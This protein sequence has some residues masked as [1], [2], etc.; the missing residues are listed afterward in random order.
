MRVFY[1]T[2]ETKLQGPFF[3]LPSDGT[4]VLDK[5]EEH[6][7]FSDAAA[8]DDGVVLVEVKAETVILVRL[9]VWAPAVCSMSAAAAS[10]APMAAAKAVL[11]AA[12]F[13]LS[14]R[15]SASLSGYFVSTFCA[16]TMVATWRLRLCRRSVAILERT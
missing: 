10:A 4:M 7:S 14:C 16:L 1:A 15:A 12:I 5:P 11:V 2:G 8:D 6:R 13:S 9:C 3:V